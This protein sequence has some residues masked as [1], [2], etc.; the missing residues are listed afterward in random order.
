MT[1]KHFRSMPKMR[2]TAFAS[3]LLAFSGH[4]FAQRAAQPSSFPAY[5]QQAY[6]QQPY[7]PSYNRV[8][9]VNPPSS[10]SGQG[11]VY[12]DG[13]TGEETKAPASLPDVYVSGPRQTP[14][15]VKVGQ[16]LVVE[17]TAN[18][19]QNYEWNNRE[20]GDTV[21]SGQPPTETSRNPRGYGLPVNG[22]PFTT[23]WIYEAVSPGS[24]VLYFTY[25]RVASATPSVIRLQI[26]VQ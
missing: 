8:Q 1:S 5:G 21:L 14:I 20:E 23:T 15:K 19:A 16:R 13:S 11:D 9:P 25:G 2:A 17:L 26:V 4:C 18:H 6:G 10:I 12:S 7:A 24:E 22:V 3:L